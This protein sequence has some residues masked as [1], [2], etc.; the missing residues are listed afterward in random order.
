MKINSS[1][2][3][4]F[5]LLIS[6]SANAYMASLWWGQRSEL[7]KLQESP[8]ALAD[9]ELDQL[10]AEISQIITLPS[11]VPALAT[12][13]DADNLKERQVFFK[14]A[15]NGDKVLIY[16]NHPDTN[17]RR[18][19]LYRPSTKQIINVAPI[20]LG[21]DQTTLIEK[22]DDE[23]SLEIRSGGG[24]Q[25]LVSQ[26]ERIVQEIFPNSKAKAVEDRTKGSYTGNLLVN[27]RA[28][29]DLV[30][31]LTTVFNDLTVIDLPAGEERGQT[32][33]LLIVGTPSIEATSSGTSSQ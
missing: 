24:S 27:L 19:Y 2:L 11:G 25:E 16:A 20:S 29:A 7:I 1:V 22:Q 31:K 6:L 30:Q 14:D 10:V 17:M 12:V 8:Q 21:S 5:A 18:A 9:Q 26:A 3:I 13:T 33:M 32:D 28:D 4:T 15:V 23:F